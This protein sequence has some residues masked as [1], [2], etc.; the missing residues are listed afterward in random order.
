[1]GKTI[2]VRMR[3][4]QERID[5]EQE[6]YNIEHM[7]AIFHAGMLDMAAAEARQ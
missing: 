1:V 2:T 5:A 4:V 3:R 6:L 7:R